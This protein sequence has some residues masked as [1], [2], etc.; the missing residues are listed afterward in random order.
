MTIA[1]LDQVQ[2]GMTTIDE[3]VER[4]LKSAPVLTPERWAKIE[5]I[6]SKRSRLAG[7]CKPLYG[8]LA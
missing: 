4:Q 8:Q 6:V 7:D 1:E 3:W 5:T 2:L